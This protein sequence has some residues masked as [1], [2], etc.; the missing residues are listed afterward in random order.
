MGK[1]WWILL[2]I[3]DGEVGVGWQVDSIDDYEGIY[4][5]GQ[6]S[7]IPWIYGMLVGYSYKTRIQGIQDKGVSSA[8]L[9]LLI[10]IMPVKKSILGILER[11]LALNYEM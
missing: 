8:R 11:F 5:S 2:G 1:F 4:V 3:G 6:A 7:I 10:S 9:R